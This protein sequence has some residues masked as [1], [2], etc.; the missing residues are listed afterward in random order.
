[1]DPSNAASAT[2]LARRIA[3][4]ELS[5][6]DL[7]EASVGRI[8]SLNPGLNALVG[9][10]FEAARAEAIAADRAVIEGQTCGPLHGVPC[11]VSEALAVRG[12]PH[13]AG[14]VRRRSIV[15]E[16]DSTV[17]A[18]LRAAGAIVLGVTNTAEFG[19]WS[20]TN[21]RVY[22]RTSN[23]WSR[24]HTA[25]GSNGGDAALVSAAAACFAVGVDT[26]GS[27]RIPAAFCGVFA[28]KC[29]G[30]EIPITGVYP[31]PVGRARRFAA[32][33]VT[34]RHAHDLDLVDR[35]MRGPDGLDRAV[36]ADAEAPGDPGSVDFAFRRVVVTPH[37]GSRLARP[38]RETRRALQAAAD[39]LQ[40]VGGELET[41]Q[42]ASLDRAGQIWLALQHEAQGL[43]HNFTTAIGE[44]QGVSLLLEA[45]RV[46]VGRSPHTFAPLA[47]VAT[48]RLTKG[49][50]ARIQLLSAEGR[51][52]RDRLNRVLQDGGVLVLPAFSG[53]AERHGK[54]WRHVESVLY[55]ALFNVMQMP[56]VV[57][58]A[59][60]SRT[61]L[62]LA[63]QVVA[64]EGQ[65]EVALA[66]ARVLEWKLGGWQEPRELDP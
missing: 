61:G 11:V 65:G 47:L 41:W 3:R 45:L 51:R 62:P 8:R 66:A 2:D 48:E 7:V 25:G 26:V 23:P 27:S 63:V 64:G 39:A 53:P 30:L 9:D 6:V 22:G 52:L 12:C 29:T 24:A 38:G 4:R 34:A 40:S 18:R 28:Y 16:F 35:V 57:V 5:A 54:M 59:G 56:A 36:I 33:S 20:E 19:L 10:R 1:M 31:V 44:G 55:T 50:F 17:V 14:M 21:N 46:G 49:S 42:P 37:M 32:V 60:V 43:H 13:S 58:P 15:A